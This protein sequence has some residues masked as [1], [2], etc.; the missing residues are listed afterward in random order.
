MCPDCGSIIDVNEL[1]VHQIEDSVKKSYTEKDRL[2]KQRENDFESKLQRENE[3]FTKK[4]NEAIEFQK[5]EL[6]SSIENQ[7][8]EENKLK[9]ESLNKELNAKSI[10]I[11]N[12]T[13]LEAEL[14]K[15]KRE[16]NEA[17]FEAKKNSSKSFEIKLQSELEKQRN[18]YAQ[19]KDLEIR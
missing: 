6:S 12:L 1:L 10:K 14:E 17:I 5:K 4:L 9:F 18:S 7:I 3:I 13:S 11:Q 19:E 16:M 15:T 2:L 8:Q